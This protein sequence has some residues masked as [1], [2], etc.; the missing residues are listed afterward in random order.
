MHENVKRSKENLLNQMKSEQN[1]TRLFY[2]NYPLENFHCHEMTE[3]EL[4][5]FRYEYN[6]LVDQLFPKQSLK[7]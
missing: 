5:Q 4:K 1:K 6:D 7:Q 2:R 3:D